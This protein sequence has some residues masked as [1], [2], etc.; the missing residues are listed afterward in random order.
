MGEPDSFEDVLEGSTP[1]TAEPARLQ[2]EMS[3]PRRLFI[4]DGDGT[5]VGSGCVIEDGWVLAR[6]RISSMAFTVQTPSFAETADWFKAA[7]MPSHR[8]VMLDAEGSKARVCLRCSA[9]LEPECVPECKHCGSHDAELVSEAA[10]EHFVESA[11]TRARIEAAPIMPELT[12]YRSAVARHAGARRKRLEAIQHWLDTAQAIE[13]IDEA[14]R[15][16]IAVD[17]ELQRAGAALLAVLAE[18]A[19]T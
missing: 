3:V 1:E 16:L 2:S 9:L 6:V 4:F 10:A 18:G 13:Q 17:D 7:G 5:L 14:G 19:E 8:V 12:A 15:A 11:Q